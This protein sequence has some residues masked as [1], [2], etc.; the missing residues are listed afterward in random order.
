MH[1]RRGAES[2]PLVEIRHITHGVQEYTLAYLARTDHELK[3]AH[4]KLLRDPGHRHLLL[5]STNGSAVALLLFVSGRRGTVDLVHTLREHRGCGHARLLAEKVK[6]LVP[7]RGSL[8]V[9]SPWCTARAAIVLWLGVGFLGDEDLLN[10]TLHEDSAYD[11]S[12]T[13]RSVRV[14]LYWRSGIDDATRA[15]YLRRVA[16]AHP[17]LRSCRAL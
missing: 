11:R 4:E 12:N 16:E 3:V 9:D 14:T 2:R 7:S 6:E 10:C 13:N 8:T 1:L 5:A 17:E 15:Q